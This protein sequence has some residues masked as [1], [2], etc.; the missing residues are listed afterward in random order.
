MMKGFYGTIYGQSYL[1]FKDECEYHNFADDVFE[2]EDFLPPSSFAHNFPQGKNVS[3]VAQI[4][5]PFLAPLHSLSGTKGL[6]KS[7]YPPVAP[8]Y[9][10]AVRGEQLPLIK[11]DNFSGKGN[12]ENLHSLSEQNCKSKISFIQKIRKGLQK[13]VVSAYGENKQA[14]LIL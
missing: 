4:Y 2:T 12:D 10:G 8:Q 13:M 14:G 9:C 3:L 7:L 6:K 5:P 11:G 1:V